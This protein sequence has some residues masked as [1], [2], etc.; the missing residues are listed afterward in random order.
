MAGIGFKLRELLTSDNDVLRLKGA[1]VS[2]FVTAGPMLFMTLGISTFQSSWLFPTIPTR[3]EEAF[4][5]TIVY[6]YLIA[7]ISTGVFELLLT[8]YFS[9]LIYLYYLNTIPKLI[10]RSALAG[11]C[12]SCVTS[13]V[14]ATIFKISAPYN[15]FFILLSGIHGAIYASS[16]FASAT[17]SYFL[18]VF[19]YVF[20]I[21][22]AIAL[23]Y[24]FYFFKISGVV[25]NL[26][27]WICGQ[28]VVLGVIL[29]A[30]HR[31]FGLWS[32]NPPNVLRYFSARRRYIYLGI[33]SALATCVDR[34]TFWFHPM[35]STR[36]EGGF[37]NYPRYD[38]GLFMAGLATIPGLTVFLVKVETSF[39]VAVRE[40]FNSVEQ[41]ATY[42][43]ISRKAEQLNQ[44]AS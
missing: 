9:D 15:V 31:E 43:E 13:A 7:W 24:S 11:L 38:A 36:L 42:I 30:L 2:F 40:E 12:I 37:L 18:I 20:G 23:K 26:Y 32:E 19:S 16:I 8:R 34:L 44:I 22:V 3:S 25:V 39:H 41:N 4:V 6:S 10:A 5:G 29:I 17:R 28:T 27:A 21:S 35:T 14:L 1:A 33:V